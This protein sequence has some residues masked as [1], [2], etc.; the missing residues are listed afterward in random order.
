MNVFAVD[1]ICIAENSRIDYFLG[2]QR[3]SVLSYSLNACFNP[4][5]EI[6]PPN[7]S[8]TSDKLIM[9]S[10]ACSTA[11]KLICCGR[12]DIFGICEQF[13]LHN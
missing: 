12:E 5:V 13:G 3:L 9:E 1:V 6:S 2:L 7:N 8:S 10:E 11:A 4:I